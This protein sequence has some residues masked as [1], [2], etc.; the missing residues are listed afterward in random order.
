MLPRVVSL[1][2]RARLYVMEISLHILTTFL[3]SLHLQGLG[4]EMT[5][6]QLE[7]ALVHQPRVRLMNE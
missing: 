5:T 4:V 2:S 6:S 3:G 7:R 1:V